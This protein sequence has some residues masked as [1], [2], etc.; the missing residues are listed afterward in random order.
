[1]KIRP[2]QAEA[3]VQ[4]ATLKTAKKT[5]TAAANVSADNFKTEQKDKLMKALSQQPD[6]RPEMLARAQEI[7]ADPDYPGHDAISTVAQL[8]ARNAQK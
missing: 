4:P 3:V 7:A 6:V 2:I 5:E 8:F 1:M